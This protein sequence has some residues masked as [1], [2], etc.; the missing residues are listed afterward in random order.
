VNSEANARRVTFIEQCFGA[1]GQVGT[2]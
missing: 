1:S 2:L